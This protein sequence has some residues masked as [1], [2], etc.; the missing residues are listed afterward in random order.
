MDPQKGSGVRTAGT[1]KFSV[2]IIIMLMPNND[3]E[4]FNTQRC[5][6]KVLKYFIQSW[7]ISMFR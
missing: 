4:G 2:Y 5:F 6:S 1:D 3:I 7:V